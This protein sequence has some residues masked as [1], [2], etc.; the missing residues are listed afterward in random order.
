MLM[1]DEHLLK[2]LKKQQSEGIPPT[3]DV[4]NDMIYSIDLL[5]R[6]YRAARRWTVARVGYES[7]EAESQME[8]AMDDVRRS[9]APRP[10]RTVAPDEEKE[11]S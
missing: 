7:V 8:K 6:V 2:D 5:L 11:A 3:S 1:I 4:I 10:S 9:W